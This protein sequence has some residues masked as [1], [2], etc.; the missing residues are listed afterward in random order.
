MPR[1][2]LSELSRVDLGEE[3][4]DHS[5]LKQALHKFH[6]AVELVYESDDA[7]LRPSERDAFVIASMLLWKRHKEVNKV[8][9]AVYGGVARR[10]FPEARK[11]HVYAQ[12]N[13]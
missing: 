9:G 11:V 3:G 5:K 2:A 1:H 6:E 12:E 7:K 8:D 13:S 10:A 4:C